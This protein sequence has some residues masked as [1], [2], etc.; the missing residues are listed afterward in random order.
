MT[1]TDPR[2]RRG[3]ISFDSAD[4][5]L[6]YL[7]DEEKPR[8]AYIGGAGEY[9]AY[10]DIEN[11]F[12]GSPLADVCGILDETFIEDY[13]KQLE[14]IDYKVD[15]HHVRIPL[16][17]ASDRPIIANALM[18]DEGTGL[19]IEEIQESAYAWLVHDYTW[20]HTLRKALIP[21]ALAWWHDP[22]QQ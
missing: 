2:Y 7:G 5:Y 14:E 21:V 9:P 19:S 12:V 13:T 8:A 16:K 15:T 18:T 11:G 4:V 3:N 17:Y 6:F 1:D 22:T 20:D 10:V